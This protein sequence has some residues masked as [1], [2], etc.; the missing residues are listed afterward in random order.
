[1]KTR[2]LPAFLITASLAVLLLVG[3][4][5]KT[6]PITA[7]NPVPCAT[8]VPVATATPDGGP[9]YTPTLTHTPCLI[10]LTSTPTVTPSPTPTPLPMGG[11]M[12][13]NV[14]NT[15]LCPGGP[16]A[17]EVCVGQDQKFSVVAVADAI[18]ANGYILMQ[19]WLDYDNQ[20]LV[21]KK[22]TLAL[23]PDCELATFLT[24]KDAGNNGV[25]AACLTALFGSPPSF[26]IGDL[27]S[28]S[29]TCTTGPSSS[30]LELIPAGVAPAGVS[31]TLFVEFGI[32]GAQLVP[33]VSG[34]TVNCVTPPQPEPA[35]TDGDG[36]SDQ[37]EIGP[38]ETLGGLR[39]FTNPHD[40]Y[41]V[42]GPGASLP[43]DGVVDLPNDILGVIQRFSPTGAAPYDVAFDRGPSVGPNPWNMSA[44][45]GVID[46]PNDILG[47]IQQF[48]H[49]CQ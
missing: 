24:S 16:V 43:T 42:L 17:G 23:W 46:L 4:L 8:L 37:R 27:Y 11:A 45:D 32:T 6:D 9:T 20:G 15:F 26:H 47:V 30:Q 44:P 5:T 41:D 38:D 21:H 12:S 10:K 29:F 34:I 1:M 36:C 33:T 40:F 28:F 25:V 39:D 13:L 22:N 49:S 31:G 2:A 18:P 19:V 14:T 7:V 48:N 35:D 3:F